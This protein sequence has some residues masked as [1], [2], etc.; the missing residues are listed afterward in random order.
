MCRRG[1]VRAAA[2][3]GVWTMTAINWK[4]VVEPNEMT[5]RG[6][7][8]VLG[9]SGHE[10]CYCYETIDEMETNIEEDVHDAMFLLN[11]GRDDEVMKRCIGRLKSRY[12][13]CRIVLL[14]NKYNHGQFRNAIDAGASG[15]F[16]TSWNCKTLISSIEAVSIGQA[17][18]PE[19]ALGLVSDSGAAALDDEAES[20]IRTSA[21]AA[22]LL[23]EREILVLR[24]LCSAMSNKLIA[25][26][27][28][29]SEANVKVHVKAILRK[30][31]GKNRTE[32][33][34]WGL[35]QGLDPYHPTWHPGYGTN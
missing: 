9:S 23:S 31:R 27:C 26:E 5:R 28:K 18:I 21:V 33:A 7:L 22:G 3:R 12:Q 19:E 2:L 13:N 20:C 32:A 11:L 4:I 17:V 24:C 34:I 6:L 30:I 16:L 25:R 14:S 10:N 8:S 1:T 29:I 15:Y 35:V